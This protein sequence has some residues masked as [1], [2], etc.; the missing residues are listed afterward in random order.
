VAPITSASYAKSYS[1][2]A[3]AFRSHAQEQAYTSLVTSALQKN[4]DALTSWTTYP[5]A[6]YWWSIQGVGWSVT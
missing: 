5:N 3:H 6:T 2:A 1:S 4:Y